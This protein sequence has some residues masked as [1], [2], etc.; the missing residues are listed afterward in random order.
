MTL[1][2]S[3]VRGSNVFKEYLWNT[4]KEQKNSKTI[5]LDTLDF[6]LRHR[7]IGVLI[8]MADMLKNS[9]NNMRFQHVHLTDAVYRSICAKLDQIAL[10]VISIYPKGRAESV[11]KGYEYTSK[12]INFLTPNPQSIA[13]QNENNFFYHL[14][15]HASGNDYNEIPGRFLSFDVAADAISFNLKSKMNVVFLVSDIISDLTVRYKTKAIIQEGMN[16]E[17]DSIN[18]H[19]PRLLIEYIESFEKNSDA[20]N[21]WFFKLLFVTGFDREFCNLKIDEATINN[22]IYRKKVLFNIHYNS[23]TDTD[24][25]IIRQGRSERSAE[26]DLHEN[27][28]WSPWMQIANTQGISNADLLTTS[29]VHQ[30]ETT[31]IT[32]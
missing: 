23:C 13:A 19:L 32:P 30:L 15:A 21:N 2:H 27:T 3:K 11:Y 9:F 6:G 7:Y 10:D 12:T 8:E 16:Q 1:I 26:I 4:F 25:N 17:I 5:D 20:L 24:K 18:R 14:V 22:Y 28:H 29:V 31:I